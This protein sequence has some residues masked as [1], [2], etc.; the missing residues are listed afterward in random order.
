MPGFH[1][2]QR[3]HEAKT[4]MAGT[5]PAMTASKLFRAQMGRRLRPPAP[6]W[7]FRRSPGTPPASE[8]ALLCACGGEG[9]IPG[10]FDGGLGGRGC[11]LAAAVKGLGGLV[12]FLVL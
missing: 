11:C 10:L 6:P 8:R 9:L 5:S 7:P 3:S 4:W 1:V 12:D 2:L